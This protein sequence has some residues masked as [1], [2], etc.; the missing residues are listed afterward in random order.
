MQE[1]IE[2]ALEKTMFAS[3]WLRAPFYLGL[4]VGIT[5]LL[6]AFGLE[7]VHLVP[8]VLAGKGNVVI[9]IL[10]LVG[11]TLLANLLIIIIF[12][13]YENFVS[14]INCGDHEGRP[15]WMGHVD[16]TDLKMNSWRGRWASTALSSCP[17]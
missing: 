13:G 8:D 5:L 7:F 9:G 2:H 4:V 16:F 11:L 3:R 6:Y 1:A 10:L 17:A 14:K 15:D 12:A